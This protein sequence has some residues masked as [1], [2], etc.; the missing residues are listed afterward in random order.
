MYP[1]ILLPTAYLPPAGYFS[2]IAGSE[3]VYIEKEE[4]YVRQTLRNRC[5]ILT[6][7]G[8]VNL[9]VPVRK[10]ISLKTELKDASIDY[11]KRWQ[12]V[13]L[14]AITSAYGRAP[15]FLFY[16]E[17]F[18]R[19]LLKNHKFLLDLNERLLYECMRILKLKK[20]IFYT[21]A[22]IKPGDAANDFRY[23][24]TPDLNTDFIQKTYIRVFPAGDQVTGLSIIDLIFNT[25]PDAGSYL[26]L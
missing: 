20:D 10:G 1:E 19:I 12:Q 13:H 11:S 6:V 2:L 16:Y 18:E 5:T 3:K 4:N 8:P 9:S 22:F 23:T 24:A 15:F 17:D 21:T 14:G 7:N 25:G 26:T